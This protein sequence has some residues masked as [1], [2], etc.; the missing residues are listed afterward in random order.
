MFKHEAQAGAALVGEDVQQRHDVGAAATAQLPESADLAQRADV[1]AVAAAA[2]THL[3]VQGLGG[4]A[5]WVKGAEFN[6]ALQISGVTKKEAWG[7]QPWCCQ[8]GALQPTTWAADR[9][10]RPGKERP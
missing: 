4:G 6:A 10:V 9:A 7:E 2:D 8:G 3:S 1:D 5:A